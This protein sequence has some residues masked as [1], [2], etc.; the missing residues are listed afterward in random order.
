MT[1]REYEVERN[2]TMLEEKE[3]NI[4]M[5]IANIEKREKAV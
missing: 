5:R 2:V 3:K 1:Q 4:T